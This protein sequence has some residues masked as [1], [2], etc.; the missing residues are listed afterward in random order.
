MSLK[1]IALI[2]LY[3]TTI[4]SQ[5][6][7]Y[8]SIISGPQPKNPRLYPERYPSDCCPI[9]RQIS[10]TIIRSVGG[11]SQR[12]C[13][14]S[15][16]IYGLDVSGS[17]NA[18]GKW[19]TAK[20]YIHDEIYNLHSSNP[21]PFVAGHRN[22][23]SAFEFNQIGRLPQALHVYPWAAPTTLPFIGPGGLTNFNNALLRAI[24]IINAD[25]SYLHENTCVIMVTD[26]FPTTPVSGSTTT[27]FNNL[28]NT[29]RRNGCQ[30]CRYCLWLRW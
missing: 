13:P 18:G 12:R 25:P 1:Y 26:G 29:I 23:V 14:C 2:L 17:M 5:S 6:I 22:F 28:M 24:S 8:A 3:F 27:T 30:P 16:F 11:T 7:S 9:K 20:N 15:H 4:F 10:S 21:A 19:T